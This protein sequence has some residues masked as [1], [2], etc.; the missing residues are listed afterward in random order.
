MKKYDIR[1]S[2]GLGLVEIGVKTSSGAVKTT[3]QRLEEKR[4]LIRVSF[5][6]GRGGWS[7]LSAHQN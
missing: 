4:C 3:F 1:L 6:N 5:K 7:I 2:G